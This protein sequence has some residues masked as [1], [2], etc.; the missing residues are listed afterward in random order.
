MRPQLSS[1]LVILV[2]I[3][4]FIFCFIAFDFLNKSSSSCVILCV[5][6]CRYFFFSYQFFKVRD[7]AEAKKKCKRRLKRVDNK[8]SLSAGAAETA[9]AEV[10][11]SSLSSEYSPRQLVLSDELELLPSH[12]L[13]CAARVRSF[14]FDPSYR[15]NS[16]AGAGGKSSTAGTAGGE[17]WGLLG[18]VNN[19]LEIYQIP[20]ASTSGGEDAVN[21]SNTN[22]TTAVP[23]KLSV[24]DL[25]GHK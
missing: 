2:F 17:C 9:A 16:S 22:A 4:F 12:T 6:Q 3:F 20:Y 19:S 24:I 18:L 13:R 23:S 21:N 7:A 8:K 11:S 25:H 15:S 10:S 1:F 5:V 14:A